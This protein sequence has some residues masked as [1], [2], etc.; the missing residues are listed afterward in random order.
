[1]NNKPMQRRAASLLLAL[2]IAAVS[3]CSMLSGDKTEKPVVGKN[4]DPVGSPLNQQNNPAYVDVVPSYE[5]LEPLYGLGSLGDFDEGMAAYKE[6]RYSQALMQWYPLA[7][8]RDHR[9][10]YYIGFMFVNGLGLPRDA[11]E[12]SLWLARSAQ[13][14]YADAE[15]ELGQLYLN[16]TGV[17]QN[18]DQAM[19]WLLAAARAGQPSA[20]FTVGLLYQQDKVPMSSNLL[21]VYQGVK[22]QEFN[23]KQAARWYQVA[24]EQG[25]GAAQNNLGWLYQNGLGVAQDDSVAFRWYQAS[26]DQGVIDACFNLGLMF[27]QGKGTELDMEKAL[28][29]QTKAADY[30]YVPARQ[31]LPQLR[32][33]MDF[34]EHSLVLFGTPLALASRDMMRT[35]L[36]QNGAMPMRQANNYWYDVYESSQ[37]LAGTDRLFA[38]YSLNTGKLA[39]LEY[40]FTAFNDPNKVLE[41]IK[42]ISDKYGN[43]IETN[44]S[45]GQ[46]DVDY[47]WEVKDTRIRVKRFWPDTTVYLSYQIGSAYYAML[48]EMPPKNDE[49]KYNLKVETY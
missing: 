40:R 13:S 42:L 26:A 22:S 24:A 6:Q 9:A 46:G 12:G 35:I 19:R 25:H 48:A 47:G 43:P 45:I 4:D 36:A 8:D 20:Q 17:E 1:M 31:R 21:A 2:A 37:T 15:F 16:G 7:K 30:G 38:G 18:M 14:G 33:Q 41:I 23:Y 27:E 39:T 34:Y 28:F 49:T 32:A 10:E 5:M 44:G 3:G 29:W 11:H